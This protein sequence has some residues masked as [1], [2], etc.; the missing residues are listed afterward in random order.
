LTARAEPSE[1]KPDRE[2]FM[3]VVRAYGMLPEMFLLFDDN[4]LNVTA[5]RATGM[6]AVVCKGPNEAL[7]IVQ[8]MRV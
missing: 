5:A 4:P 8:R 1:L 7:R 2:A 3:Q 6:H